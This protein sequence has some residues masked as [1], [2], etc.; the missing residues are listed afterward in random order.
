MRGTR[1]HYEEELVEDN[2]E[3]LSSVESSWLKEY[4]KALILGIGI[5]A[6]LLVFY[7]L[8]KRFIAFRKRR[9]RDD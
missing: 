8:M 7:Q 4:K 5:I 1:I 6:F 3:V 2:K 9:R